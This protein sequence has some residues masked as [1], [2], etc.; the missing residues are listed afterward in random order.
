MPKKS[1]EKS[2]NPKNGIKENIANQLGIDSDI[3]LNLSRIELIGNRELA[4]ENYKGIIEY[5]DTIIRVKTNPGP[6]KIEGKLLEIKNI[7]QEMLLISGYF[8]HISFAN[9]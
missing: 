9:N 8:K 1:K 4:I 6:L 2:D 7:T 3:I 5:T